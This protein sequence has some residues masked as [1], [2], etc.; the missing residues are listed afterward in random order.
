[1]Y[2]STSEVFIV[3]GANIGIGKEIVRGIAKQGNNT[4]ILACRNEEKGKKAVDDLVL[5]GLS[6]DKLKVMVVDTSSQKSIRSFATKFKSEHSS[7]HCLIN[8]AAIGGTSSKELSEDG[9]ELTF[10]TNVVGYFLLSNLLVDVLVK[11]A[12]SR[13][14][15]VASNYAGELDLKDINFDHRPYNKNS[16]YKQSKQA[17]RMISWALADKLKDQQVTVNAC[18]PGVIQTQLLNTLGF[19]SGATPQEGAHT[20]IWLATSPDVENVTGKFF[21]NKQE[22]KCN[23]RDK[24]D[25][26]NLWIKLNQMCNL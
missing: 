22:K 26:E 23:F 14:V 16:A 9:I 7:L 18:H 10:A 12:P 13:I 15:N 21:D 8:N 5:S 20:P 17:N 4:V 25:L 6:R 11:S 3:T 1:M 19:S 24:N 2:S